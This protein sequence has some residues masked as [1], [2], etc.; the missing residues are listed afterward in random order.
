MD[1]FFDTFRRTKAYEPAESRTAKGEVFFVL[2]FD[3]DRRA[4]LTVTDKKGKSVRA[5][6]RNYNGN[7][8][9]LLRSLAAIRDADAV[10]VSWGGKQDRI[11]L[12][13]HPQ[14]IYQILKCE[15]VV[16]SEMSPLVELDGLYQ[17][18]ADIDEK[19]RTCTPVFR[20][21]RVDGN[22]PYDMRDFRFITDNYALCENSIVQVKPIGEEFQKLAVLSEKF[23]KDVSEQ[24]LSL[25]M[26]HFDNVSLYVN[27]T[28]CVKSETSVRALP[29]I[30]FEKV[31]D[32]NSLF[33]RLTE[34]IPG[35]TV[36][37]VEDFSPT[38]IVT[39]M[40]DGS[41]AVRDV[42]YPDMDSYAFH[43]HKLVCSCAPDKKAAK[44]V[45]EENGLFIIPEVTAGPFLVRNLST[46]AKDFVLIS[47]EK[48]AGYKIRTVTPRFNLSVSSGIDFL[49]GFAEIQIDD[50]VFTLSDFLDQYRRNRYVELSNGEK[51]IVDESYVRHIERLFDKQKKGRK[52]KLSFFDLPEV[53]SLLDS[54][55]DN[56]IFRRSREF[57][58]GFNALADSPDLKIKGLEAELRPYQQNGVKWLKY[59]Y[60]NGFGG[61]LADDMGL[62]KTVQAI[63][64]LLLSNAGRKKG[65]K[66]S[67]VVM[68]R[69]LLF[70][71]KAEFEKFAPGLK[72]YTYYG[73]DRNLSEASGSDVILTT[74]ALI[75]NDI[76]SF[77]GMKFNCLILDESQNIKNMSAKA[78]Q[79]VMMLDAEHKFALSGTP[80]ENR[81]SELYSLF[82]FLN[83]GMFGSAEEFNQRYALPI[84]K[85]A[86]KDAM[87]QLRSRINPFLLRR[88]KE[89]VLKDLPEKIDQTIYVEMEEEH[90]RFYEK[91]RRF[92]YENIK[93]SIRTEGVA[94]SQFEMF[95]ALSE[96]R[97]IASVPESLSDGQIHSSKIPVISQAV[98][99]AVENGHKVVVFFNF[100]AGIELLGDELSKEGVGYVVM[101]GAT[102]DRQ[103]V[104]D[105]FQNDAGCKVMLMTLK[106]GG[107]GLNLTA[108]DTVFVAE[109]WWNK[110]AEEQAVARLHRIGQKSVVHSFSVITSSSI[111]ERIL[112][113]QQQKAS[114][115]E[116]LISSDSSTSK[117]IS[118]EDID[119]IFG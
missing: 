9:L 102:S 119:F 12:D 105:R 43:L 64:L 108:A 94:R 4:Y 118:E 25:L 32:D 20:L 45:Y 26:S 103:S 80:V 98:M 48:L 60:D 99:E 31:T 68:P 96:L 67:M 116:A 109:P 57:Y 83:P 92:Y 78:S 16:N 33:L 97:R 100:I 93:N 113:L 115:V 71:W 70:N 6:Y 82:R 79:A 39:G 110:A 95:Q 10:T 54:I 47:S 34:S 35:V 50:Q 53:S 90:L 5:D 29:A 44:D 27:G 46:L 117:V 88:V 76:E 112:Q 86:D 65:R 81:L 36:N 21:E 111:E 15:N 40:P 22:G 41:M 72:L 24:Y 84:Q 106:T 89:E 55:P 2:G 8:F 101:T 13:S 7:T 49:E 52:V 107:V 58:A 51:G 62:G 3:E 17:F 18:R 23:S 69:T 28:A 19:G 63:S 85:D 87:Q 75:R 114:L 59:L 104:V 77:S 14:L 42:E 38:R 30:V 73:T 11:Y 91:R 56:G 1:N 74:Y 37:F 66:P 61:C